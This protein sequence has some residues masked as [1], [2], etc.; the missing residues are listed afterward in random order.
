MI[1][2]PDLPFFQDS[3]LRLAW[4]WSD[5]PND[6][7]LR[8]ESLL[9]LRR[10][11]NVLPGAVFF[12]VPEGAEDDADWRLL[13]EA[14][15]PHC[16]CASRRIMYPLTGRTRLVPHRPTRLVKLRFDA[17]YATGN[18]YDAPPLV[19]SPHGGGVQEGF[20][21]FTMH[22]GH[23][24]VDMRP[25]MQDKRAGLRQILTPWDAAATHKAGVVWFAQHSAVARTLQLHGE[26]PFYQRM[27]DPRGDKGLLGSLPLC[28][29]VA[30]KGG[31]RE[32]VEYTLEL[33]V[34]AHVIQGVSEKSPEHECVAA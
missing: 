7:A 23:L 2:N 16:L 13:I 11:R 18:H 19:I 9:R 10:Y 5:N 6:A 4:D 1:P 33:D 8:L 29:V 15:E 17:G 14:S 25:F 31:D 28:S 32:P 24:L 30:I 34:T 21:A 3:R 12:T 27:P 20:I 22:N 26:L